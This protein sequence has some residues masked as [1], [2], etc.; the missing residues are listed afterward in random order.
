MICGVDR[1]LDG[2]DAPDEFLRRH[3]GKRA[4]DDDDVG[5]LGHAHLE[6]LESAAGFDDDHVRAAENTLC[7]LSDDAR[8]VDEHAAFHFPDLLR[9]SVGIRKQSGNLTSE[10]YADDVNEAGNSVR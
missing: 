9:S 3:V 4:V 10:T 5:H 8:I 1:R 6:R 7:D 2:A